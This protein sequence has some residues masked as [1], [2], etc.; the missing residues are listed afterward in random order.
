MADRIRVLYVDD[1]PTLLEIAQYFLQQG[2]EF[3]VET[4]TSALKVLETPALPLYD[5]IISDYQMPDMD[6]I[7]FLKT[8]RERFGDL[9]FILFTGKGREEV[10]IDAINHGVDFY[11]Q[12][13][14][15]PEALFA[16]LRHK[17]RHAVRRRV[18][19]KELQRSESRLRSF[20][21]TTSES[22]TLVDEEGKVTEWNAATERITGIRKEKALGSY[23]WDLTYQMLPQEYRT[24]ERRT[25]IE[26]RIRTSLK[27][28][29]PVFDEP[30]IFE[31]VGP[32]GRLVSTRQTVFPIRTDK[33]FGIGSIAQ[34]ITR[35][36]LAETAIRESEERFRGM[37]ERS[38]D[39]ILILNKEMSPIYISPSARPILGFAPEEL[40]G[41]SPE[42]A[43]A[44]IFSETGP[45]L[46][47]A[48]KTTLSGRPVENVELHLTRKDKTPVIV[49]MFAVPILRD[50]TLDGVQVSMRDITERVTMQSA[51]KVIIG[52][53]VGTTG[54]DS[55]RNITEKISS[56]LGAD[57]VM[58][59]EIQPD[60][61]TVR[62][63]SMQL[64]GNAIAE[65]SYTLK[66]TPC[67]NVAEK[68]FCHYPDDAARL[69]PE[70]KDLVELNIRGYI[71][72]SLKNSQGAVIG[73]L[74]ALFR[75]P[76]QPSPAVREIMEII[77]T[78]AGTEI[79]RSLIERALKESEEKFR[80]I[81]ETSPNMI[82]EIDLQGNFRYMSPMVQTIL[83]YSPEEVIGK[84]ILDLV[85]GG[86]RSAALQ[87]LMQMLSSEEALS[88]I[89]FPARHRNGS[90]I[91]LEIR[92]ARL[93]GADGRLT[94]L[95]GMAV[96]ITM[97]KRAEIALRES[98][99]KFRSFV[100]N[101][102]EIIFS[103]TPDGIFTYVSPNW[104]EWLGHDT[105]DV[106]GKRAGDFI[107]PDDLP[108][109]REVFYQ[110]LGTGKKASGTEY[111]IRH[112][113]GSWRWN[114]QSIAPVRDAGG[115]V[116]GIQGIGHDITDRKNAEEA[117]VQANRKLN[118]LSG[119]TRHDIK[120]QL[121]VLDGYT[122]VLHKKIPDPLLESYFSRITNASN[123]IKSMIEFTRE[124]EEIGMHAPV[125]Q[126]IRALVD[127][128]VRDSTLD[129]VTLENNL[130]AGTEVFTDPLIVKVIF[131]LID[132]AVRHGGKINTIRFS[133]EEREGDCVIVCEDD[134]EGVLADEKEKI[135]DLGFGKNTGFGLAISREILSITGIS[136]EETG[137]PGKGA[138]FEIVVP[139]L[140]CRYGS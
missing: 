76:Y 117:L 39:L 101:A 26:Q 5:I 113:D 7:V 2:G 68:G 102:N 88:P 4:S 56:W 105:R 19:E 1:E 16:E 61:Q 29:T 9:P 3:S 21:E 106:I 108:R 98:E 66:G 125:W 51:M 67:E 115:M 120:N 78:K 85:P 60:N 138:R 58:V 111:R 83:G 64:D 112:K 62:V 129:R 41:K 81:V 17:I 135:F 84:S 15:S 75:N 114:I 57:C 96:D 18:T 133:L 127:A 13:G 69:F 107:H 42:F 63:L 8:I 47:E 33:G 38:S 121:I 140:Q 28:G 12:K 23:L 22:V 124:Y 59:G 40:V 90:D 131:N 71:G 43:M 48:V 44:T 100:E 110:T 37:A 34:D 27:T 136:I 54:I 103:L 134:G 89:E 93:I 70:S 130:S 80:S 116:V 118:L 119:I 123:R 92:P 126:D 91:L 128:A 52:S 10:V 95:R 97:R 14:G 50:G 104:T 49:S 32:D 11:I 122:S 73:I 87:E 86:E 53:M 36:R 109:N 35:E 25:T 74:C 30:Q 139:K 31:S 82:W 94:G 55:L 46:M 137:E 65:F 132:N 24:E 45:A 79:E 20:V 77:A 72:T 6:G 99:E